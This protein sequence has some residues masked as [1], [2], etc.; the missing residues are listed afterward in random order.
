MYAVKDEEGNGP[1]T[2]S[3]SKH[4]SPSELIGRTV[5]LA[6]HTRVPDWSK[7]P[8]SLRLDNN[9][10]VTPQSDPEGN[11]AGCWFGDDAQG[12]FTIPSK[13]VR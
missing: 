8:M 1:G 9:I 3:I 11:E 7:N 12:E 5:K 2:L 6:I 4:L 10:H 13:P